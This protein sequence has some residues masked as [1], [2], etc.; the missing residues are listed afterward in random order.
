MFAASGGP[1]GS[2]IT[3]KFYHAVEPPASGQLMGERED[4]PPAW[5]AFTLEDAE[6]GIVSV[7]AVMRFMLAIQEL[8]DQ[9]IV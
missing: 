9:N 3:E 1:D 8:G 4:G 6:D 2:E 5:Q 7:A